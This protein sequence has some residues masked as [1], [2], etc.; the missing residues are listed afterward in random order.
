M[1]LGTER[2]ESMSPKERPQGQALLRLQ[3]LRDGI[4]LI[5]HGPRVKLE[6]TKGQMLQQ[7]RFIGKA[8]LLCLSLWCSAG[9]WLRKLPNSSDNS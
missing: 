1:F 2:T 7:G 9:K 8:T 5:L 3:E 6:L 4:A